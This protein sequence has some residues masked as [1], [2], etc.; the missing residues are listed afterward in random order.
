[1]LRSILVPLDGSAFSERSL[2]LAGEV[3]RAS[4]AAVH[5]AHV[6]V[7]PRPEDFFGSSICPDGRVDAV[8]QEQGRLWRERAYLRTLEE[9]FE[10]DPALVDST[11]LEGDSVVDELAS[12][13]GYV[14]SDMIVITSHA[15][16]GLWRA[17]LGSTME[18][19]LRR[20]SAP[21]LVIHPRTSEPGAEP[22]TG[23]RHI[24]VPLDG[25]S[26]AE[27]VLATAAELARATG[28]RMTLLRVLDEP[29]LLGPTLQPNAIDVA[30]TQREL[31][32]DYLERVADELRRDGVA[33]AVELRRDNSVSRAVA[34]AARE[35]DA[36]LIAMTTH[37]RTGVRRALVAGVAD[38]LLQTMEL[39]FLLVRPSF[40][41]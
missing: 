36:D 7:A 9:K 20:T 22:V 13:A 29:V 33:V 5:L 18:G 17:W 12:Y 28:A 15:H 8:G 30:N 21:V 19:V 11:I 38:T 27:S 24:L 26:V 32:R 4:G 14:D 40:S 35:L 31:G 39:P 1:M 16:V 37:R 6:H 41:A 2:P 34:K 3:A 10:G 23:I 25:S